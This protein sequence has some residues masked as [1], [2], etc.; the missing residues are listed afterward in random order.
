VRKIEAKVLLASCEIHRESFFKKAHY[1]PNASY[2]KKM[3]KMIEEALEAGKPKIAYR[4]VYIESKGDDY[5]VIEGRKFTSTVLRINLEKVFK[6]VAYVITCGVELDEWSEK[7]S[8]GLDFFFADSI[9]EEILH[10]AT[11][12]VFSTIDDEFNLGKTANMNPG[13]LPNWPLTEQKALFSLL[14]NVKELIGVELL[15][16]NL[17]RPVKSVSG[18]HFSSDNDYVNCKLCLREKCPGRKAPFCKE[19][20]EKRY[21]L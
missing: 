7:Y 5:V 16:S 19:E 1:N 11:R 14:G 10:N 15:E 4:L 17:M 12:R 20:Y 18:F 21:K 8:G 6:V 9:K 3:D 13:S 2:I